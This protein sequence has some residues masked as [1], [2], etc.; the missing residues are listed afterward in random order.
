VRIL[1]IIPQ[2]FYTTRGTPLSAYHRA[3]ELLARGHEVDILTYAVGE[4]PPDLDVT[5]YRSRGPHFSRSIE[6]G[7]SRLKIWFDFL[8]F[9]SLLLR[10]ARKRYDLIYAHEEGAFLARL[11]GGLFRVPYIYDM[12]SSLPLQI[13][14]WNFSARGWVIGLFRWVERVSI[15]GARAVVAISPAVERVAHRVCPQVPTVIIV[16]H[17]ETG[18]LAGEAER[19][20]IRSRYGISPDAKVVLYTG[21]FVALQALDL[22]ID[23]VPAVLRE[24]PDTVFLLVGGQDAEIAPLR[25]QARRLGV[26]DRV[27]FERNRPQKEMP[28]YMA[29]ADVLASPRTQGINPPGKLLSYLASGRPVVATDTL[30]HNQLLDPRCSILTPP[31]AAGFARGLVEALRDPVRGAAAVRGAQEF[32]VSYCSRQARDAAYER[33]FTAVKSSPQ[34]AVPQQAAAVHLQQPDGTGHVL[35]VLKASY[36]FPPLGG[37]GAKVAHGIARR[38]VAR[39]QP[40]DL[41]T[42]SFRG[43]PRREVVSGVQVRRIPG[44]R[45]RVS[46]CS[47]VEM[48]PYVL[49]APWHVIRRVRRH[50]YLVN[51][52]HF[53]FPDGI[54]A[55]IVKRFTGMPYVITAHGSDVPGYNPNRFRILHRLLLPVWKR[56]TTDASLII[57]PSASIQQLIVT[58]NPAVKTRIIP[59]AI[60]SNKFRPG[61]KQP[62]RL[63][64]VTRMFERKGVQYVLRA[65]AGMRGHFDVQIVGDGPYLAE[66]Q[67]LAQEL[68]VPCKF[69]GHVDNDSAEL[70]ELYE[71]AAIFVFTSESENFPIVLLEAM[72]AGAAIIT[73]RGTGCEEVVRDSGLLVPVCDAPAIAAALEQLA[74][75]PA[76]V[77]RLGEAAR[78]RVV[79]C[80][81]WDGIIDQHLRVY[82]ECARPAT[83]SAVERVAN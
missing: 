9:C 45:M 60:D 65:L 18:A 24:A 30:V 35:R 14:D 47:F 59:N 31:D 69:W 68:D 5:V 1:K 6:A 21:S 49:L 3:R 76:L 66:L 77:A 32:L 19:A 79:D 55:Y 40:V 52:S 50:R 56:I 37:G 61:A 7:P 15:R 17:F 64:I 53:I 33:L 8:L 67:A 13:T 58:S 62:R 81:D 74:A 51:H 75:D 39:G 25:E 29:A 57:C 10:L 82:E 22:L 4:Q 38:L 27:I 23:A 54:V 83:A 63:L 73:T 71:T 42:M 78:K 80:F 2:A 41:L 70:K 16:N 26:G 46:S 11:A 44:V 28:A 72:I 20:E 34:P 48:I 43:L 12:H 36:E